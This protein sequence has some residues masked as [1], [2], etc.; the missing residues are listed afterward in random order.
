M[1]KEVNKVLFYG[2]CGMFML[3]TFLTFL[4]TVI[5]DEG[6]GDNIWLR[7]SYWAFHIFRLPSH[8]FWSGKMN[9]TMFL[10]GL[11]FNCFFNAF[12]LERLFSIFKGLKNDVF[13]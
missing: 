11:I 10:G 1:F 5:Y 2:L 13:N 4:G 9:G 12:A 8:V 7:F 6:M 3:L